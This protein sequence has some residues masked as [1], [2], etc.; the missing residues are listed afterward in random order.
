[1]SRPPKR[2]NA[3][4]DHRLDVAGAR[5]VG[6]HARSVR[7]ERIGDPHRAVAV[8]VG[9]DDARAFGD[10][11]AGDALAEPRRGAGDDGDLSCESHGALL[12]MRWR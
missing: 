10:E 2:S 6:A 12:V 7:A 1:M 4:C 8:T 9:D 3:A 11:L 5:H